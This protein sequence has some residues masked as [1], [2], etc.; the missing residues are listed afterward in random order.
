MLMPEPLQ[1][2]VGTPA[3]CAM[4]VDPTCTD[5]KTHQMLQF[6]A[7][8]G[9]RL[10]LPMPFCMNCN[11]A[12]V[13]RVGMCHVANANRLFVQQSRPGSST[14]SPSAAMAAAGGPRKRIWVGVAA[15][16]VGS[17][18][19]SEAWPLHAY[20]LFVH[21]SPLGFMSN[22]NTSP[23]ACSSLEGHA[24]PETLQR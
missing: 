13:V 16:A 18:G 17:S 4:I 23:A 15:S 5:T 22:E 14:L 24:L 2:S 12:T 3:A 21:S 10:S 9:Q 20:N 7:P 19:F 6:S 8:T 11:A 1:G